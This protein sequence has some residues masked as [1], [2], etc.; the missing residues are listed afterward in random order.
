MYFGDQGN[1][2][3]TRELVFPPRRIVGACSQD[4]T[5]DLLGFNESR[6]HCAT[7]ANG[8]S[9]PIFPTSE[10]T[11]AMA[12]TQVQ[13]LKMGIHI[14]ASFPNRRLVARP[15]HD[16]RTEGRSTPH[17]CPRSSPKAMQVRQVWTQPQPPVNVAPCVDRSSWR[18]QFPASRR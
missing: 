11:C 13:D 15:E 12:G 8:R 17:K 18:I 5:G 9:Y 1:P 10:A 6:Y 3:I 2:S 14:A 4:R 16:T 7:Q